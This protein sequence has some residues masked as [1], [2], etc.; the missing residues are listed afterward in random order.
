MY[1][2]F[3]K[4]SSLNE[5]GFLNF[6]F[7]AFPRKPGRPRDYAHLDRTQEGFDSDLW[8][9]WHARKEMHARGGVWEVSR[10]RRWAIV[11]RCSNKLC[12]NVQFSTTLIPIKDHWWFRAGGGL[13]S[14]N[15]SGGG[16]WAV[17]SWIKN[18]GGVIAFQRKTVKEHAWGM[19]VFWNN[20]II[21]QKVLKCHVKPEGERREKIK[22]W[23]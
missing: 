2:C 15:F 4:G 13:K 6:V 10:R 16:G 19:E 8:P 22:G 1:A 17:R 11:I 20:T 5:T 9:Q 23:G 7:V 21:N 3:W 14:Q 12:V 18:S